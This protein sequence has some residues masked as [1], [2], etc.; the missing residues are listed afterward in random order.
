MKLHSYLYCCIWLL[1]VSLTS[2]SKAEDTPGEQLPP[3][4]IPDEMLTI[5][6]PAES[7]SKT[8]AFVATT[9]WE[10]EASYG[11]LNISPMRGGAG[12]MTLT[13]KMEANTDTTD[14]SAVISI[15]AGGKVY[16]INVT[17]KAAPAI[18]SIDPDNST[19]SSVAG[20]L[21]VVITSNGNWSADNSSDWVELSAK[22][23]KGGKETITASYLANEGAESRSAVITFTSGTLSQTLTI[24]QQGKSFDPTL[25]LD[26]TSANV[27]AV[28]GSFV[29]NVTSN[30]DWS[31]SD[32]PAWATLS[33]AQGKGN[34]EVT[35]SY[36]SNESYAV[37][38]AVIT[39]T[40]AGKSQTLTI[41]Q[42]GKSLEPVFSID[43]STASVQATS[44][45]FTLNV[46]A[47]GDWNT[48]GVPAW[49]TLSPQQG[50]GDHTVFVS[51]L[52]NDGAES[53]SAVIIFTSGGQSQTLTITQQGKVI[54]PSLSLSK[55]S[56][57][58]EATSGSFSLN[59][60]SNSDWST[61]GIPGWA[62][63]SPAQGKG[64]KAVTVNYQ[65][66]ESYVV[67]SAVITFTVAGKSQ[68]LT[69]TQQGKSFEPALSI[70]KTSANV[71][72][73]SGTF[74]LNVTSNGDWSTSGVPAWVTLSPQ[75][76]KGDHMVFVNYLANDRFESRSAVITFTY[77]TLT[78]TLTITQ[79]A[80]EPTLSIDKS[81]ANVEATSGSFTL[82]V[83]S[84]CDWS[85]SD[86]PAWVTLSPAQGKGDKAV[87]ATYQANSST[88]SRSTTIAF[89][90]NNIRKTL[91]ITQAGAVGKIELSRYTM[92]AAASSAQAQLSVTSNTNWEVTNVPNWLTVSPGNGTQNGTVT[93][94]WQENPNATERSATLRFTAGTDYKEVVVTQAG[95][96]ILTMGTTTLQFKSDES[97]Q[98]FT[99]YA[100]AEWTIDDDQEWLSLSTSSGYE[101]NQQV[102]VYA[103]RHQGSAVRSGIVT[104]TVGTGTNKVSKQIKV[105]QTPQP[106]LTVS[107]TQLKAPF[108]TSSYT[109]ALTSNTAWSATSNQTWCVV[110]PASGSGNGSIQLS[111]E[112]NGVSQSR[113][114]VIT[115]KAGSQAAGYVTATI[116]V[117]QNA[118]NDFSITDWGDNGD[119]GGSAH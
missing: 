102:T 53:R 97:S 45:T 10:V 103:T 85:T 109:V 67:R 57:N 77:G 60:T 86:I 72:A 4:T 44:G 11:W 37:R 70:D 27:Q 90:A 38:S 8:V 78:Q 30:S 96:Y 56:A 33:P 29:L 63:L 89:L 117:T 51:Y 108:Q 101:G 39:F 2:C 17:Q 48:S 9:S 115:L 87:T 46:T 104:V 18:F 92:S 42:Q 14:R 73:A 106:T 71:Q 12:N 25:S 19:V 112:R 100:N 113:V 26:K 59:V 13:V 15:K 119:H 34:K 41:T 55:T 98:M 50:K 94:A 20:T 24:T 1:I 5:T 54:E 88:E 75:Q 83:S 6:S 111:V 69:I 61:S 99:F 23:G 47:S 21:A 31:T 74:T 28:A 95:Q 64:D 80:T 62:T 105:T 93:I 107:A 36:Q 118:N 81:S 16:K 22:S 52:A 68:T 116:T 110:S 32:I 35:V 79:Q 82:N 76:G 91:T 40:A 114:A 43:K 3:I 49:V 58:V 66:N 65:S 84:N 7:G